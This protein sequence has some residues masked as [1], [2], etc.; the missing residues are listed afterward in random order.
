MEGK[1]G[2]NNDKFGEHSEISLSLPAV[3]CGVGSLRHQS[4][5]EGESLAISALRDIKMS[6]VEEEYMFQSILHISTYMSFVSPGQ[7]Q[8]VVNS[9]PPSLMENDGISATA[10]VLALDNSYIVRMTPND[11]CCLRHLTMANRQGSQL[12]LVLR[13][14]YN[15]VV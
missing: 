6:G 4:K 7:L 15:S 14:A 5:S 8:A 10:C 3:R 13:R 2:G 12:R 1:V 9:C 11:S